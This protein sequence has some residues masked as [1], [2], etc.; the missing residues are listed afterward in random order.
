M[1]NYREKIADVLTH[2][3]EGVSYEE[4][5]D[6]LEKPAD[7]SMGDYAQATRGYVADQPVRSALVA[8]A[9]GAVVAGVVLAMR[10]R[11]RRDYY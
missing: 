10:S 11:S 8:A 1:I 3:M 7:S 9:V 6:M 4:V 5:L 2:H